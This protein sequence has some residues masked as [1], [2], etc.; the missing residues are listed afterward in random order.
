M[1]LATC[2]PVAETVVAAALLLALAFGSPAAGS[3]SK[4][5]PRIGS[6]PAAVTLGLLIVGGGP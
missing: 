2:V 4:D 1:K 6:H 5:P 3:R